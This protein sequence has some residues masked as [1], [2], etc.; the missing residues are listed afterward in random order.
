MKRNTET[1]LNALFQELHSMPE[2]ERKQAMTLKRRVTNR[3]FGI[4]EWRDF[5][6]QDCSL[7]ESS[8]AEPSCVW[9]GAGSD[10]MHL[11]QD[12]CRELGALL[13]YF[14]EEGKLLGE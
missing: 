5:Y 3:G 11:T 6:G 2:L 12:Q 13:S 1:N 9:L 10:R 14:A 8:L 7:Q 4:Y